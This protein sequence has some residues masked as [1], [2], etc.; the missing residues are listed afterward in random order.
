MLLEAHSTG[1]REG[2][3]KVVRVRKFVLPECKVRDLFSVFSVYILDIGDIFFSL[4]ICSTL[5]SYSVIVLVV[6][7]FFFFFS[8]SFGLLSV[9]WDKG[10]EMLVGGF[11]RG[12][13]K[14]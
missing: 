10:R 9:Q 2:V 4:A 5:F 6:S 12:E 14:E 13:E 11:A 3:S 1:L 8:F 7:F